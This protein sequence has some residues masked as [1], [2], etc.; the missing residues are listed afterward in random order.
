M[1]KGRDPECASL[2]LDYAADTDI[3]SQSEADD[4]WIFGFGS[5]I[6][7]AGP[8]ATK[9]CIGPS[10]LSFSCQSNSSKISCEH[11]QVDNSDIQ[12]RKHRRWYID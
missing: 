4:L 12:T 6:W 5:L 3:A 1:E 8:A 9:L 10:L 7:K 2:S 11:S